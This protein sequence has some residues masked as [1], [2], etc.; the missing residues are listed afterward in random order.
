MKALDW[1]YERSDSK[2]LLVAALKVLVQQLGGSVVIRMED[3]EESADLDT[4]IVKNHDPEGMRI[5][6][7]EKVK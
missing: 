3:L 1:L 5:V 2:V 7:R 6:V 4:D